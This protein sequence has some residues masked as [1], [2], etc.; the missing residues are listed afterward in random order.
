[1]KLL[2]RA[3]RE[4]VRKCG[5]E[6]CRTQRFG[7]DPLRDISA[8]YGNRRVKAIF[9]VGANE[10]QTAVAY[11]AA[12]HPER[13]YSFEPNPITFQK[14]SRIAETHP[15]IRPINAALGDVSEKRKMILTG[16]NCTDSLLKPSNEARR[17]LGDIM[18]EKGTADIK[19]FTL[20]TFREE[21]KIDHLD[22]LKLDV[23]G[24]EMQVL[25]GARQTLKE[26]KISL[27]LAEVNFVSLYE[28]QAYFHEIYNELLGHG[29]QMVGL[30]GLNYRAGS[31]LNWA[32]ALFV[33]P[34]SIERINGTGA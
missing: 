22:L 2:K 16:Y 13:I 28:G 17:Y 10:G 34:E 9:D 4:A 8:I 15:M 27:I 11:A 1:M 25:K 32:D 3:I 24:F 19:T 5:Y 18:L 6:L 21:S 30:Y 26:K 31:Y 20:D 29:F 7:F 33:Q 23:Q 14:L 12:F